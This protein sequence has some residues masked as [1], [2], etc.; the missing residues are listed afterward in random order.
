MLSILLRITTKE[1][2]IDAQKFDKI[3]NQLEKNNQMRH[4]FEDLVGRMYQS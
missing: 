1:G 2:F 4:N 3:L